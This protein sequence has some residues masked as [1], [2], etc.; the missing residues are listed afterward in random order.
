MAFSSDCSS[1]T[2]SRS[3][4]QYIEA[5]LV[6][7]PDS[8][9][10]TDNAALLAVLWRVAGLPGVILGF[11]FIL[12]VCLCV[13][14]SECS[15]WLLGCYLSVALLPIAWSYSL[16]PLLPIV[17]YGLNKKKRLHNFLSFLT[18]ALAIP[19]TFGAVAARLIALSITC[20]GLTLPAIRTKH[21]CN[22]DRR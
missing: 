1:G 7:S 12:C 15:I 6:A 16:L 11:A 18:L 9:R 21:C 2:Q 3:D 8:I 17:F 22:L 10:R 14:H 20:L 5:N 19:F 4:R 13:D